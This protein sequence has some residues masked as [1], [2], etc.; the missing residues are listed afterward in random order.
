MQSAGASRYRTGQK[1]TG[2][3]AGRMVFVTPTQLCLGRVEAGID[4]KE[5]NECCCVSLKLYL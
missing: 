3:G 5:M 2:L 4:N 1:G